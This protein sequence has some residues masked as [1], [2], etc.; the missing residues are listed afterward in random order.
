MM[1]EILKLISGNE[2]HG[3]LVL[4]FFFLGEKIEGNPQGLWAKVK[5]ELNF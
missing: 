3:T 1:K 4:F 2:I 5:I